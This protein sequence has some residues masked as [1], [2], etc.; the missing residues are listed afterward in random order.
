MPRWAR[1]VA[2]RSPNGRPAATSHSRKWRDVDVGVDS[3]RPCGRA[4]IIIGTWAIRL[5]AALPVPK[6]SRRRSSRQCRSSRSTASRPSQQQ[7]R[8]GGGKI[9]RGADSFAGRLPLARRACRRRARGCSRSQRPGRTHSASR[10][11]FEIARPN[12]R[13]LLAASLPPGV[14]RSASRPRWQASS[15]MSAL[16]VRS[17]TSARARATADA[18]GADTFILRVEPV[19]ARR[20][21]PPPIPRARARRRSAAA[22]CARGRQRAGEGQPAVECHGPRRRGQVSE[23]RVR[24]RRRHELRA[25]AQ[26]LRGPIADACRRAATDRARAAPRARTSARPMKSPWDLSRRPNP[27]SSAVVLPLSSAPVTCPFSMRSVLRASS[28]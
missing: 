13:Q 9:D 17:S 27:R 20:L 4:T 2:R 16:A 28:P 26:A 6:S 10:P 19:R 12:V 14:R 25:I 7:Q 24:R 8:E 23:A 18:S 5:A 15:T 3:S 1:R 22:R 21:R 11:S